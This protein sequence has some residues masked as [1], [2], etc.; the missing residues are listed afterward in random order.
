[1]P[2]KDTSK[3]VASLG[4]DITVPVGEVI[5]ADL[6]ILNLIASASTLLPIVTLIPC[7]LP[8]YVK[9]LPLV[10]VTVSVLLVIVKLGLPL[11]ARV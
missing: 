9:L 3:A 11:T 2:K 10:Q 7:S 8:L 1:M 6:L 4:A 5:F